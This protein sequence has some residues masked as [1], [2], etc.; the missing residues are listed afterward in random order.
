M[1]VVLFFQ[2]NFE[3]LFRS[4]HYAVMD[5]C[6]REYLF[7]VDFFMVTGPSATDLFN[8]IMSK[9][10]SLFLVSESDSFSILLCVRKLIE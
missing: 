9:T 7:L 6:C 5:N 3:S 1:D 10:V 2:H 4:L 8:A